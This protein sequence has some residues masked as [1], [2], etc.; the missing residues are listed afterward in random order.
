[1]AVILSS[2]LAHGEDW[3]QLKYDSR[4]SGNVVDR[5]V[6]PSPGLLGA[7]PLSDAIFTAPV[8]SQGRVFVVDGSGVAFCINQDTL[9]VI[10]RFQSK[11]GKANCNNVSSPA[12]AGRFLHFGTMGGTYYILDTED[13]RVVKE[14]A[15]DEPI[16]GAPVVANGRVY[17]ASLGARIYALEPDGTICWKWDYV[18][19]HLGFTGDRWKGE[20]WLD[21]RKGERIDFGQQFCST[22]DMAIDG[23]TLVVPVGNT[24]LWLEDDGD[25]A[26]LMDRFHGPR[27]DIVITGVSINDKGAA[28]VQ[29]MRNDNQGQLQINRRVDGQMISEKVAGT[30]TGPKSFGCGS[31]NSVSF[32]G[33]DVYRCRPQEGF[34]LSRYS[35]GSDEPEHLGGYPSNSSPILLRNSAVYGGLDGRLYLVPLSQEGK[36]PEKVWS[37]RTAFDKAIS[38]PVAVADGR[39]YF[40]CEDG[41]LYILGAKGQEPLPTK[42]LELW[43]IRSSL[44]SSLASAKY[45][46][47]TSFGN[48]SNTNRSDQNVK[49]PFRTKWIRRYDGSVK[50]SSTGGG[51]R[52]YTHTAEGQIFAVEQE[53]GRQLW[54]RYFPGAHIS[55]T[56]PS[57]HDGRLFVPQAGLDQSW[58]R[59]L[60]AETGELLW[61][62]LIAGSPSWNR[63][64]PPII[65]GNL[66]I[67][68][69]GTGKYQPD[70][71][72]FGH[73]KIDNFPA[74][75]RP[76]VRAWNIDTGEEAW[77]IDFSKYGSGGDDSGICLTDGT[78]YYSCYFGN[79]PARRRGRPGAKGLTAAINPATGSMKWLTTDYFVHGGCTISA[80]DGRLYLGGYDQ[81]KNRKSF[82]WCLD[83]SDGSLVWESE[84]IPQVIKVVT[85][86]SKHLFVHSQNLKGF[87]LDKQTGKIST[88]LTEG[89]RCTQFV[90]SEPFLF[91][92]NMDMIDLSDTGNIRLVSTGPAID[93]HECVG[94]MIS[95]GR[96]F[97]TSHAGCLQMSKS[98]G[99]EATASDE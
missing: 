90:L 87:L 55:Y 86:G 34:G 29:L 96:L 44:S 89:Y 48:W 27:E 60:D 4:H 52:L 37:F 24:T 92:S 8:V 94:T 63:Q 3:E 76:L 78:L 28:Y 18:R 23:K 73:Q 85:I 31:F 74:D 39:I 17:F 58:L 75:H 10:W 82:V 47:F 79:S 70:R 69:Y 95:N 54:Q 72:L 65:H 43:K 97:Y 59:C 67:Y 22:R 51:G 7:V 13:G 20:D 45:D 64:L 15:C 6:S 98:Y 16:F 21:F 30:I 38:A 93:V 19:E 2:P 53:T 25:K 46:W 11:G 61:E 1:M 50:H 49:P 57:Y 33:G 99:D 77:K 68:M 66:A 83:A 5:T 32:H 91:G 84:P 62:N 71:W 81:L 40:G 36:K 9:E 12:I 41:Y 56:S 88:T 14:I 80:E 35:P 42:D 26:Q